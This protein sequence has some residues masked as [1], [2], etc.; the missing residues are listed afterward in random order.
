MI[1]LYCCKILPSGYATRSTTLKLQ[2]RLRSCIDFFQKQG[3]EQASW[4]CTEVGRDSLRLTQVCI[5][6]VAGMQTKLCKP[7]PNHRTCMLIAART[8]TWNVCTVTTNTAHKTCTD[9]HFPSAFE[10]SCDDPAPSPGRC[11][12]MN[13]SE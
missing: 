6:T 9:R 3:R 4:V 8:D 7:L 12:T 1:L 2:R 11:N 5:E 10:S 13:C